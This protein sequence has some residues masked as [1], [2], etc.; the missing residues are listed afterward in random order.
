MV[1]LSSEKPPSYVPDHVIVYSSWPEEGGIHLIME[2]IEPG[3][4]CKEKP[5]LVD[6]QENVRP[7]ETALVRSPEKMTGYVYKRRRTTGNSV[8]SITAQTGEGV[9]ICRRDLDNACLGNNEDGTENDGKLSSGSMVTVKHVRSSSVQ[10]AEVKDGIS[11]Q[12]DSRLEVYRTGLENGCLGKKEVDD[13]K[14]GNNIKVGSRAT[15]CSSTSLID[16][17]KVKD[18]P[19]TQASEGVEVCKPTQDDDRSGSEEEDCNLNLGSLALGK[20]ACS[21]LEVT[22]LMNDNNSVKNWCAYIL[23]KHGLINGTPKSSKGNSICK[24]AI[25]EEASKF[26]SCKVCGVSDSLDKM[27]ICDSCD[28]AFHWTCC[29]PKMKRTPTEWWYCRHCRP[30]N[31]NAFSKLIFGVSETSAE[32]EKVGSD[33]IFFMLRD[34]EPYTTQVRIGKAFQ[35]EVPEW[36]GH[37]KD[38]IGN[39]FHGAPLEAQHEEHKIQKCNGDTSIGNWLQ[40]QHVMSEGSAQ[41]KRGVICGKWRRAPLFEVQTSEWECFCAILWDPSHADCAVPQ[42]ISTEEVMRHLKFI[43][44]V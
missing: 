24:Q 41:G 43:E 40:C 29:Y 5:V 8:A 31:R 20:R 18:D 44:L 9:E 25:V 3:L 33:L 12:T 38:D 15:R 6:V 13:D 1:A 34:T 35:A 7:V 30:K 19:A 23:L 2:N 26:E 21:S 16:L 37:I 32:S 10:V 4:G 36:L 28:E 22:D 42:E 11:A 39:Q 14:N 17:G 27:L